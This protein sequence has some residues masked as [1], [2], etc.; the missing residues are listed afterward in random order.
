[1]SW[2]VFNQ[3][4]IVFDVMFSIFDIHDPVQA[5]VLAVILL[6]LSIPAIGGFVMVERML[7]EFGSCSLS[8][9]PES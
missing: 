9:S 4:F 6:V 3:F 5:P 2:L 1:M 7:I 8:S